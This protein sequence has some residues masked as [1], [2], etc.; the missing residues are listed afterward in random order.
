MHERRSSVALSTNGSH[1]MLS[2]RALFS[3][4]VLVAVPMLA[5]ALVVSATAAEAASSTTAKKRHKSTAKT[6]KA[7]TKRHS[8][9]S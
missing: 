3:A 5:A 8:A 7:T 6:A 1:L 2:R 9:R 4:P